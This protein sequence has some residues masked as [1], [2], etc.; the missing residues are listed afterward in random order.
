MAKY[1]K[2]S[3]MKA[4][5]PR[6]PDAA[7]YRIK[8]D[9]AAAMTVDLIPP[10][11]TGYILLDLMIGGEDGE[12]VIYWFD[13]VL[14]LDNV[15]TMMTTAKGPNRSRASL[16][17]PVFTIA[18]SSATA[19]LRANS[20]TH[21]KQSP[22]RLY[23]LV[24]DSE[25]R[26]VL[27]AGKR[28]DLT[29]MEFEIL[30]C[31]AERPGWVFTPH[32]MLNAA[33]GWDHKTKESSM[34]THI[35]H[36]RRKLGSRRSCIQTVRGVGYRM[37]V[38]PP[39]N[40]HPHQVNKSIFRPQR[41][42]KEEVG[43]ADQGSDSNV[44][45]F[46]QNKQSARRQK[47]HWLKIADS[48]CKELRCIL[49]N[50]PDLILFN[51]LIE[52]KDRKTVLGLIGSAFRME[53]VQLAVM[54]SGVSNSVVSNAARRGCQK[55]DVSVTQSEVSLARISAVL[56]KKNDTLRSTSSPDC[57]YDVVIHPGRREV[58]INGR[59]LSLSYTEFEIMRFLAENPYTVCTRSQILEA[60]R[61][62]DHNTQGKSVNIHMMNLRRKLGKAR[63]LI[64][65]I[66]QIGYRIN[67]N[68]TI[69][70]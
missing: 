67:T 51:V 63:Q 33:K 11:A 13:Q 40:R 16:S 27:A 70:S 48:P 5:K 54:P 42:M 56:S 64:E 14:N 49:S 21:R 7:R 52:A 23:D 37:N 44:I 30:C 17:G 60:A 39:K 38:E 6:W 47:T 15:Q 45:Q 53:D 68:C 18:K 31:L 10:D 4:S 22:I 28:I 57:K 66:K 19:S 50:S 9:A 65:T 26:E 8:I 25:R 43:G 35:T 2:H 3:G 61:G 62:Q 29:R 34:R 36:L 58:S 55:N 20:V 1:V 41:R 12:E 59:V 69:L 46:K 32:Q 24:I